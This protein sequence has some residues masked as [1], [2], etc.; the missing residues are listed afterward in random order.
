MLS[1]DANYDM[2]Q[3]AMEITQQEAILDAR[4]DSQVVLQLMV[5]KGIV[6]REE[7]ATMRA[8]VK[9]QPKYKADYDY[10]NNA[11]QKVIQYT[12]DPQQH[13]KDLMNMKLNGKL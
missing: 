11:K 1:K 13:L 9:A 12:Q 3:A 8:K 10:L 5:E 4:V 2:Q 7:V 6:T